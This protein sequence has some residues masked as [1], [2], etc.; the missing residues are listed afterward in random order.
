MMMYFEAHAGVSWTC[1]PERLHLWRTCSYRRALI[2][3]A[4]LCSTT[5]DAPVHRMIM[6]VVIS[7]CPQRMPCSEAGHLIPTSW[8]SYS[9]VTLHAPLVWLRS[10]YV[11]PRR[12]PIQS[13]G[14]CCWRGRCL[15]SRAV[16]QPQAHC[17]CPGFDLDSKAADQ[18]S[19][20]T[21]ALF[22]LGQNRHPF[23]PYD[24]S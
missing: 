15:Q 24:R 14:G 13:Q 17:C 4:V 20:E 22:E 5:G 10:A 1:A 3:L 9:Y 18:S 8:V 6:P 12:A 19:L 21:S 11:L 2:R 16:V 23:A 7:G